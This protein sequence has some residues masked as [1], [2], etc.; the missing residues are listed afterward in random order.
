MYRSARQVA[1]QPE[2]D[3]KSSWRHRKPP[4]RLVRHPGFT[5]LEQKDPPTRSK[6]RRVR[7]KH[8]IEP[9]PQ[10]QH[11][12][13]LPRA[14]CEL[15]LRRCL[16]LLCTTATA[17]LIFL[18][19]IDDEKAESTPPLQASYPSAFDD[20]MAES[21]PPLQAS[22]PSSSNTQPPVVTQHLERPAERPPSYH[23]RGGSPPPRLSYDPRGGSPPPR[24]S[25]HPRGGSPPPK[26]SP[27]LL[28][29]S[30]PPPPSPPSPPLVVLCS[31][32]C[33]DNVE[34]RLQQRHQICEDGGMSDNGPWGIGSDPD[35]NL[36]SYGT[37]CAEW[38]CRASNH[39][40]GD[41]VSLHDCKTLMP[42]GSRSC[43][44]QLRASVRT[45]T[46]TTAAATMA[47]TAAG[48][49][50]D[51]TSRLSTRVTSTGAPRR[52]HRV[53]QCSLSKWGSQQQPCRGW[54]NGPLLGRL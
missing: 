7:G 31:D 9:C 45:A 10:H 53:P 46:L 34:T 49:T 16:V 27:S 40:L 42:H 25:Y 50:S 13:P 30:P 20:E 1:Q 14:S 11:E 41:A 24:L 33:R 36:C 3:G 22:W 4:L 37:D 21:T 5:R 29:P 35:S 39:N 17:L 32:S 44:P 23:S 52:C 6:A 48:P 28:P 19:A 38:G 51:P 15:T 8:L 47:P 43:C 54:Y 12:P 26:L 2:R 18:A